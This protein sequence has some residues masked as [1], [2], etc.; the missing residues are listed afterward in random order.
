M[1]IKFPNAEKFIAENKSKFTG[2][3]ISS[4]ET[5]YIIRDV[6]FNEGEVVVKLDLTE[7]PMPSFILYMNIER[8]AELIG[9]DM[10]WE[11]YGF[12]PGKKDD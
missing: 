2:K 8:A 7:K 9:L 4:F 3:I 1:K 5:E 10:K 6:V 12:K 11:A